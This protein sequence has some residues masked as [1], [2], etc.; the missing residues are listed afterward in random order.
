MEL[1]ELRQKIIS[2][3]APLSPDKVI[4]FGSYAWG[5][6]TV[7]SDID[8]YIVTRDTMM[9]ITYRESSELHLRY[10]RAM[11]ELVC[12]IPVD[13]IVHTRPMHAK[14]LEIDSMFSRKI[15]HSGISLV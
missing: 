15:F 6:P 3:L 14:F 12:S 9:P 1:Q 5:N 13:L 11:S 2:L 4:L 7:D 10:A 8:L